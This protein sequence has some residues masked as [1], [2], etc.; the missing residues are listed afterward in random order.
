LTR[1]NDVLNEKN[2]ALESSSK[3]ILKLKNKLEQNE[4]RHEETLNKL[5][6]GHIEEMKEKEQ[7]IQ[8]IE[9]FYKE[10]LGEQKKI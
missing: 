4:K 10:E 1:L 8:K 6:I 2:I 3:E 5:K 7:G 9:K